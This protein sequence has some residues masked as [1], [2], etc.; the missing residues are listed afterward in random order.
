[1][2]NCNCNGACDCNTPTAKA[3]AGL[4]TRYPQLNGGKGKQ[5]L[6]TM[7][8]THC[9]SYRSIQIPAPRFDTRND[10]NGSYCVTPDGCNPNY[11]MGG[12]LTPM[13]IE[14]IGAWAS[15]DAIEETIALQ[16]AYPGTISAIAITEITANSNGALLTPATVRLGQWSTTKQ[17]GLFPGW[18]ARTTSTTDT[19][20]AQQDP[21]AIM[22]S[23]VQYSQQ[24]LMDGVNALPLPMQNLD[25][26]EDNALFRFVVSHKKTVAID[27]E[28]ALYI[29]YNFRA[30]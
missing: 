15:G 12:W 25:A 14:N 28:L 9:G 16:L 23:A 24:A 29:S 2:S 5:G 20:L 13:I 4:K 10:P 1:M 8:S 19:A 22:R 3:V 26:S 11:P 21:E 6:S 7:A 18:G 27:V 30:K 17:R